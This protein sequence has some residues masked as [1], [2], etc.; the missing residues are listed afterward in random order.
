MPR[1]PLR[2]QSL[3]TAAMVLALVSA[4]GKK[5]PPAAPAPPPPPPAPVTQ[6]PPPPPPPRPTP[7]PPP[8]PATLTEEEAFARL[9][10]DA[11]NAQRPLED[12]FFEF[13]QSNLSDAARASLQKDADWM[14][15]SYRMST[16]AT[17]E[18]HADSRGTNEYNLALGERRAAAVRD[19]LVSLGID[20]SRINIV[21]KGEEQ[22]FCTEESESC[23]GQN[24]R[25]HFIVTAK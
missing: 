22:P 23:W 24:R 17:V 20:S 7:P 8:P 9:S 13:D 18:G 15:T 19:Y 25:G 1:F 14:K 4:C 2:V 10:L 6:A 11:L 21:S 12:V 16:H 5:Q 3:L